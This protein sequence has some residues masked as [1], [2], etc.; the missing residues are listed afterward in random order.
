MNE[1]DD[2][3]EVALVDRQP[4]VTVLLEDPHDVLERR[5]LV[6]GHHVGARHHH[7]ADRLVADLDDAMDHVVLLLLDHALLL[8]YVEKGDELFLSQERGLG[9][10]PAGE[11]SRDDG[12]GP[13]HRVEK[14]RHPVDRARRGKRDPLRVS[15]R[16]GLGRDLG[17]QQ[18]KDRKQQR[19]K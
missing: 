16:K 3:V 5:A 18:E 7:L 1:A 4:R 14:S 9:R 13:Q 12:H 2:V 11:C 10:A 6:D 8:R 17:E 19:H 15:D